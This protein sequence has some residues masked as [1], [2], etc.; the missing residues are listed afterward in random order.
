MQHPDKHTYN[1]P[2]R[3]ALCTGTCCSAMPGLVHPND[4]VSEAIS[5]RLCGIEG[6]RL[7]AALLRDQPYPDSAAVQQ[8][9]QDLLH[10][11]AAVFLEVGGA[12]SALNL[13]QIEPFNH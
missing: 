2:H 11:D 12:W 9:L 8:H 3:S 13:C 5:T 6:L 1:S 10:R 7:P 4:A